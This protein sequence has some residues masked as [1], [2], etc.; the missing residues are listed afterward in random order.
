MK[1]SGIRDAFPEKK[2]IAPSEIFKKREKII[3]LKWILIF[4]S[5]HLFSLLVFSLDSET[6][7]TRLISPIESGHQVVHLPVWNFSP[8]P[9]EGTKVPVSLFHEESSQT[10]RAYLR[11]IDED[12][13]GATGKKAKLE[14]SARDLIK[15]KNKKT[16]WQVYPVM[17][18]DEKGRSQNVFE[19]RF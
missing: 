7:V 16:P 18:E 19:V 12:P 10:L 8:L 5:S 17:G 11:G 1:N 4:L 15:L 9:E 14:L 6:Q 2:A 13:L 3:H